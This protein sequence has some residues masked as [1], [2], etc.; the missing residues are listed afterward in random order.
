MTSLQRYRREQQRQELKRR[1]A[2]QH[3]DRVNACLDAWG[4]VRRENRKV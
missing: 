4:K 3:R 1:Q 2:Q